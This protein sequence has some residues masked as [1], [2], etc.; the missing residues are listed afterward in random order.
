MRFWRS[1]FADGRTMIF[2]VT[3]HSFLNDSSIELLSLSF[4]RAKRKALKRGGLAPFSN[5]VLAWISGIPTASLFITKHH[6]QWDPELYCT[7]DRAFNDARA[8]MPTLLGIGYN[9]NFTTFG[10]IK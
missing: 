7:L 3:H 10:S 6:R 8:V 4:P 1:K 9:R 2:F 5:G